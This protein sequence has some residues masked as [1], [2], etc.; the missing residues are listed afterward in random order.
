MNINKSGEQTQNVNNGRQKVS[1]D[2]K[3]MLLTENK[4][5][6]LSNFCKA[7]EDRSEASQKTCLT[8]K[9]P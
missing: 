5:E 7:Q 2:G 9:L 4:G 1:R 3:H 6:C 8:A